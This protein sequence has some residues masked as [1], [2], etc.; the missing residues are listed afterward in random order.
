MNET[1]LCEPTQKLHQ[2]DIIRI[3]DSG[4]SNHPT[5]GVIINADCDLENDKLDGVI[6]YLPVYKFRDYLIKFWIENYVNQKRAN[7]LSNLTKICKL[8]SSN[9]EGD[10]L[11]WLSTE[12]PE[13]VAE[14]LSI[15]LSLKPKIAENVRSELITVHKCLSPDY[16]NLEILTYFCER[17]KPKH[18][19]TARK[20][21]AD[22]K[23]NM[24]DGHFFM[25]EIVGEE[26]IGFVIRM[27]RIYTIDAAQCYS[28]MAEQRAKASGIGVSAGRIARLTP[29]Y[30]FK[31]AQLFANQF[32]RIG[33]PNEMTQLSELAV[34]SLAQQ[35]A[36]EIKL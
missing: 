31:V 12:S 18:M 6:A 7:S 20:M 27:R 22:A 28:S 19:E 32:S 9:E 29:L 24:G 15:S 2:G 11:E 4:N 33:L 26:E 16:S 21:V 35:L 25:S 1:Q 5:L 8:S 14:K 10:L 34:E 36:G 17:E 30:Q 23:K 3:H 13:T